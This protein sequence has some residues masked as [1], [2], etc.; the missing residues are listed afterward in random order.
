[1]AEISNLVSY[2]YYFLWLFMNVVVQCRSG[3]ILIFWYM[4]FRIQ[5]MWLDLLSDQI[6]NCDSM[7]TAPCSHLSTDFNSVIVQDTVCQ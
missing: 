4:D 3:V 7:F 6:E 2:A 5:N 1:M